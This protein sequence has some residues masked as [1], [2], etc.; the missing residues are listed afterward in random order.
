MKNKTRV[1]GHLDERTIEL[2]VIQSELLKTRRG[3]VEQHL[4]RCPGCSALQNEISEY[5]AEV[6][7]LQEAQAENATHALYMPDR[8]IRPRGY[9][10]QGP[11]VSQKPGLPRRFILAVRRSP[12]RWTMGFAVIV[13]AMVFLIPRLTRHDT[14]PSYARGKEEFLVVYSKQGDE[15]WRKHIAAGY[16]LSSGPRWITSHQ[17]QALTTFDVDGDGRNEVL[18]IFGWMSHSTEV[19]LQNAIVCF[20]PDGTERWRYEVHRHIVIGGVSYA[21]DYRVYSMVVGDFERNGN[22]TVVIS[23]SQNPWFPNILIRLNAKDGSFAGEYWHPGVV[24]YFER[25]DL[26][27]DG[28]EELLFAGQNNRLGRACLVVL[29]PRKIRGYAPT[30]KEFIPQNVAQGTEKYYLIFPPTDLDQQWLDVTNQAT[31]LT[32]RADGLF[33]VV[34]LELLQ[35]YRPEVYC[36]LDSTMTCVRVRGSDH[37]TAAHRKLEKEGKLKRPLNDAF[38]EGLRHQVMYWNGDRFVT[39]P[40]MVRNHNAIAGK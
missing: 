38:Y 21:D 30:P 1:D 4:K 13:A 36:Y 40:T 34:V 23:V 2:Y 7:R 20:N 26:D 6:D 18:A 10:V 9:E 39:T 25:K 32:V 37:F 5:Y 11:L 8:G 31:D 3:E 35:D 17:E 33:E 19:P 24:P 16:D 28:I 22:P 29:D 14:N 12:V 15:L 27:G